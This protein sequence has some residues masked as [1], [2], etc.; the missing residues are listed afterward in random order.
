[1]TVAI[2]R[3]LGSNCDQDCLRIFE[4]ELQVDCSFVWHDETSLPPDTT[5]VV[6]PGGFSYGDYLR[7]GAMAAHRPIMPAIKNFIANKGPVLG[8]CN[9]FQI[10]CEARIL[11]GALLTNRHGRFVCKK[12]ELKI[13]S[14]E[15]GLLRNYKT[16]EKI[17]LT[18]A[19]FNGNYFASEDTLLNL[20]NKNQIA[21]SYT[22]L[23]DAG[24]A[25]VN[26]SAMGI[27]GIFGGPNNNV[28]GLMPHP[29]RSSLSS[30][31]NIDGLKMLKG[32]CL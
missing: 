9:G 32:L 8:I 1:M 12:V 13:N 27:A 11:P 16:G 31:G 4:Q 30:L 17:N 2:V 23:D 24:C 15:Q 14:G 22:E 18:V 5:A 25:L 7:S 6:L 20:V 29:E 28:L 10:L 26:G 19:H 21:L 3:F